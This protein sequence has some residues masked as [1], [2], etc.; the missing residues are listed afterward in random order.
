MK[1]HKLPL[2]GLVLLIAG[3]IAC[4]KVPITNRKQVS[5]IP[6]S[7]LISLSLTEYQSFLK[8]NPAVPTA[9]QNS[10]MVKQV[11][12]NI[13]QAV[14]KYMSQHKLS[15]R[16]QGYKWEFNLVNDKMVNAWCM[17]GG[18]VV[19]YSGLLDVTQNETALAIVMGH[20]IAHAVARHGNERMSQQMMAQFGGVA[21]GVALQKKSAETQAIF[22]TAYGVGANV[23]V[24]LPYSRLHE[25]EADKL[26]L[27]F[28]AM[29]GYDPR[30]APKFWQRMS[31]KGGAKVP[32]ILSTHPSDET[33]IRELNKYMPEALKYYKKK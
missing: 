28:A 12:N 31:A 19:V 22:Q 9:D 24:M 2:A 30:E 13:Q 23:A 21:L 8:Q 3:L 7:E 17:P 32:E 4:S 6:E 18:K 15:S 5:L 10:I 25:T 14:V 27:I 29:A 20:E 26:G 1:N 16:L 11:G 33:R